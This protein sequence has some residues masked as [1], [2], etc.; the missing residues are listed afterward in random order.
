M[1]ARLLHTKEAMD[2]ILGP[3]TPW[4]WIHFTRYLDRRTMEGFV[5]LLNGI[6]E[7]NG[8]SVVEDIWILGNYSGDLDVEF[9]D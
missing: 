2:I 3:L 8:Y 7:K 6:N 4:L 1:F 5:E 9:F